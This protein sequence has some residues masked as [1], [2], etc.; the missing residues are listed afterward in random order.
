MNSFCLIKMRLKVFLEIE[1]LILFFFLIK[2]SF[3][4]K[5]MSF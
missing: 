3:A 2:N 5:V 1:D 4:N